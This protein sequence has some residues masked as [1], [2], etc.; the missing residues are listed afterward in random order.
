M[1]GSSCIHALLWKLIKYGQELG[2][3]LS[4]TAQQLNNHSSPVKVSSVH[5]MADKLWEMSWSFQYSEVGGSGD[6]DFSTSGTLSSHQLSNAEQNFPSL[7]VSFY[8]F[9]LITYSST[10]LEILVAVLVINVTAMQLWSF[11]LLQKKKKRSMQFVHLHARDSDFCLSCLA[12]SHMRRALHKEN[13][14]HTQ[15]SSSICSVLSLPMSGNYHLD[16]CIILLVLLHCEWGKR[17]ASI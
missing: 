7:W 3:T 10:L 8:T 12:A 4:P 15:S 16:S 11:S 13:S 2:P 1:I 6:T 14:S 5:Q 17:Q 9:R